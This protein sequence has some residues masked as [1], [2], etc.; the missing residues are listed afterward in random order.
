M[1]FKCVICP[2][3]TS[4][5]GHNLRLLQITRIWRKRGG[6]P[7]PRPGPARGW[8]QTP[9]LPVRDFE[10]QR[11]LKGT[12]V[13][14]LPYAAVNR[15]R[16][17]RSPHSGLGSRPLWR[18]SFIA[19]FKQA[20]LSSQLPVAPS[21]ASPLPSLVSD[22]PPPLRHSPL[23]HCPRV[24]ASNDPAFAPIGCRYRLRRSSFRLRRKL[25]FQSLPPPGSNIINMC[26]LFLA[27]YG[28]QRI[29][30]CWL[31]GFFLIFFV[32]EN[33]PLRSGHPAVSRALP[34]LGFVTLEIVDLQAGFIALTSDAL[35]AT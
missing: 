16:G 25:P 2:K 26:V 5:G 9:V 4:G 35:P 28:L 21:L 3:K 34:F 27:R 14:G 12:L 15:A 17:N 13:T 31:A 19:V 23:L 11:N 18:T 20:R 22:P 7:W 6:D 32:L 29:A 33:L 24:C 1:C 8:R 10:P 30:A